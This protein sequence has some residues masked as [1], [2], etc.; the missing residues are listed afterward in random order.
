MLIDDFNDLPE[1]EARDVVRVWA[2][3]PSWVS[4]IVAA[5]PFATVADVEDLA[6]RLAAEWTAADL[7]AALA[8]HPR[9]GDRVTA[10]GADADHSRREQSA[11]QQAA[12][13][14]A[15]R[16]AEGNRAYEE[17]FGRVFL[18]RAAGRTPAQMLS[19]LER[20]LQLDPE[21]ERVEACRQL[22]QI[23][24]LRLEDALDDDAVPE[25]P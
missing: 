13:D 6:G 23:A 4:A 2:D 11:M 12:D 1:S 19:E 17:R 24:Q 21:S 3:V 25:A 5:R 10:A 8:H 18:I 22:A 15:G 7:D 20:R 9:I 16:I 14:I